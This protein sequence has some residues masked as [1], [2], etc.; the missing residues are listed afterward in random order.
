M[1]YRA[2]PTPPRLRHAWQ[3]FVLG[4]FRRLPSPR[5]RLGR[6]DG[7]SFLWTLSDHH[8]FWENIRSGLESRRGQANL[9]NRKEAREFFRLHPEMREKRDSG[10]ATGDDDSD[11][12]AKRSSIDLAQLVGP[13]D[14]QSCVA[15][16]ESLLAAAEEGDF[17]ASIEAAGA[18]VEILD[19]DPA[20]PD[21]L[22]RLFSIA[23]E[24]E[25][26]NSSLVLTSDKSGA[27]TTV[28]RL[29]HSLA[30]AFFGTH[31][32]RLDLHALEALATEVFDELA[33]PVTLIPALVNNGAP[34]LLCVIETGGDIR[35]VIAWRTAQP[36][37]L[38]REMTHVP[39][40][41]VRPRR[42]F[43]VT[44]LAD[45]AASRVAQFST[46]TWGIQTRD[47]VWLAA[48]FGLK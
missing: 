39:I 18:I 17:Q 42:T 35:F 33:Q 4:A 22:Q 5:G 45:S 20:S 19:S 34:G 14:E 9:L 13:L 7:D 46:D 29:N 30:N 43:I 8:W 26:N 40:P 21:L 16:I 24:L 37:S 28:A 23:T 11:D 44:S 36:A 15:A 31:H 38:V 25:V 2:A 3:S 27:T 6:F 10:T 12:D 32:R 47:S 1:T 41:G 48:G